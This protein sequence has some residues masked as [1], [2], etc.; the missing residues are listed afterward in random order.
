MSSV[1]ISKQK[2]GAICVSSSA[3]F[4]A[5]MLL[6][7][8]GRH[9]D[10]SATATAFDAGQSTGATAPGASGSAAVPPPSD[11]VANAISGRLA[12]EAA[13]RP[14]GTPKAEDVLAAIVA[15]GVPLTDEA[16]HVASTIGARFCIGAKSPEGLAMSAC[17]YEDEAKAAAGRALSAK[18]FA[19]I[20]HRDIVVNK[21]T[22][23]TIL[24]NP[25]RAQSQ[26]AHDKAVAA[27]QKL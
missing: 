21:K 9:T 27:F 15:A 6:V 2:R 14:T 3:G 12:R 23:L 24:Q 13:S 22:T 19:A 4:L 10:N 25:F 7:G 16:Q 8:C 11:A 5:A 26:G 17:E 18:T 20:E 1:N